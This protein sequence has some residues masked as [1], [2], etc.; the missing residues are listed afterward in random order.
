M[1]RA[2]LLLLAACVLAAAATPALAKTDRRVAVLYF[3][4]TGNPELEMLKLGLSEMLITD[5]VGQPGIEVIE[6]GRINEILGELDLQKTDKVDQSTAVQVGKLLGVERVVIGSYFELMGQFQLIG[7]VVE[8]ETGIILGGSQHNGT[9]ADFMTLEDQLAAG[10]LPFLSDEEG[11]IKVRGESTTGDA[12]GTKSGRGK[13]GGAG[14]PDEGESMA[15]SVS[16]EDAPPPPAGAA[17]ADPLGAALAFG[18]GLDYLD[19]KDL[20]RARDALRRA[21]ELDP[22]LEAAQAELSRIEI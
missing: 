3:E 14:A 15:E 17:P 2:L 21:V 10:L 1:K 12:G 16:A 9:V 5:L 20:T 19:R 6:R 4:N 8:V 18:E 22:S 7:R 11:T 13:G